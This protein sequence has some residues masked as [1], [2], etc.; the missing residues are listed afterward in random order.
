MKTPYTV[1]DAINQ[2]VESE[3]LSRDCN[4]REP[5]DEDE[6]YEF[7]EKLREACRKWFS[8]GE[9]A[10]IEVDSET[11]EATVLEAK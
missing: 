5:M 1:E 3:D 10:T 11:G 8:Y 7:E 9:C 4:D 6:R 2:A